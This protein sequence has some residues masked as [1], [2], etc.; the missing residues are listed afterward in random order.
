M[1]QEAFRRRVQASDLGRLLSREGDRLPM[2][3]LPGGARAAFAASLLE[4]ET[5]AVVVVA[6]TPGEAEAV[7]ADLEFL[8][9]PSGSRYFPQR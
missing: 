2:G 5:P 1:I 7:H 9:G 3:S 4:L 6:A 8:L